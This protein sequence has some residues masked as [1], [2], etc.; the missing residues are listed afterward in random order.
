M[1]F[2]PEGNEFETIP[3]PTS[4]EASDD[5]NFLFHRGDADDLDEDNDEAT[6][7]SVILFRS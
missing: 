1:S 3:V 7:F 2:P 5:V 6:G 4:G